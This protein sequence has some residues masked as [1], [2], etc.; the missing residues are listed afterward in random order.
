MACVFEVSI[1]S[2]NPERAL[3]Q[4][5]LKIKYFAPFYLKADAA[6]MGKANEGSFVGCNREFVIYALMRSGT[7]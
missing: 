4:R 2:V 3:L 1:P 7:Y 6:S 5:D